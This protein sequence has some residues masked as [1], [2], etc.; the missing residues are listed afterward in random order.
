VGSAKHAEQVR[1]VPALAPD[2]A[3]PWAI[4]A[5]NRKP[6]RPFISLT[7]FLVRFMPF[8][9]TSEACRCTAYDDEG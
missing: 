5:G 8:G 6:M 7:P 4:L 1:A 2:R 3:D 9:E